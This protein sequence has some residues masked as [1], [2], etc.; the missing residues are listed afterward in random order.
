MSTWRAGRGMGR[1]GKE[2]KGR[3]EQEQEGERREQAVPFIVT[4]AHC[5]TEPRLNANKGV[6]LLFLCLTLFVVCLN[7]D[8]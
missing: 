6:G 3:R 8:V 5:G 2:G 7:T 4:Q 1:E